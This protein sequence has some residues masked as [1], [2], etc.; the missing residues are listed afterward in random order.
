VT[1][2]GAG[3]GGVAIGT[4]MKLAKGGDISSA[5]PLV[6]DT[7]GTMFDVTGTTNFSVMTVEANRF[8]M[9]QFDGALTVTD[10]S[11]IVL[12]GNANVTTAAGDVWTC[13]A[14]S[15]NTVIVTNIATTAASSSGLTSITN[16]SCAS[17]TNHDFTGF[18]SGTYD[19]YKFIVSNVAPA[20]DNQDFEMEYSTD[21]GS[22]YITSGYRY[23]L[24]YGKEG[25]S[26]SQVGSA[27]SASIP[28]TNAN[29][30]GS[31]SNETCSMNITLYLPEAAYYTHMS[32]TGQNSHDNAGEL[33]RLTG[34]GRLDSAADVDGIRF[35][36]E[37]GNFQAVG[38]IQFLGIA[39]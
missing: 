2:T 1:I 11:S 26:P 25:G 4:H 30:T 39:Q 29:G 17:Q 15:A 9:L 28:L 34:A 10:G 37:S 32:W 3:T 8:F 13:Y 20:S 33:A 14:T 27:S 5:S 31:A 24:E 22:S 16:T 18:T 36:W 21:G 35:H 6:I 19:S 7:D 38:K 23:S 12:P